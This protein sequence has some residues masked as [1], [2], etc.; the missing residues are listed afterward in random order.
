MKTLTLLLAVPAA[1]FA[2]FAFMGGAGASAIGGFIVAWF[3]G[4][5]YFIPTY[6]ALNRS[7]LNSTAIFW[8]NMLLGW[9]LI[10]W[11]A[12]LVWA[13]SRSVSEASAAPATMPAFTP[14]P[15][16]KPE[17]MRK[18]PFCAEMVKAEANV[19]RYCHRDLPAATQ[20]PQPA[21][22]QAAP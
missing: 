15:D 19:C 8:L 1:I 3:G 5:F 6:V 16:P 4:M 13:L 12:A 14:A 9:A 21:T 7:H 11:V 2:L 10:P 17:P 22:A 18:C 20:T